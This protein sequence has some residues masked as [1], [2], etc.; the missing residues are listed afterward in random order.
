MMING[1]TYSSLTPDKARKVIRGLAEQSKK[2]AEQ[3]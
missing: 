1:R 3:A 2:E